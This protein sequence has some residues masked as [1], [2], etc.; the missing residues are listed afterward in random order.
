MAKKNNKKRLLTALTLLLLFFSGAAIGAKSALSQEQKDDKPDMTIPEA[1]L[2]NSGGSNADV[3]SAGSNVELS[4]SVKM[5]KGEAYVRFTVEIQD[6]DGISLSQKLSEKQEEIEQYKDMLDPQS[7]SYQAFLENYYALI[8]EYNQIYT[9]GQLAFSAIC[10]DTSNREGNLLE[11]DERISSGDISE[12]AQTGELA[13]LS[14]ADPNGLFIEDAEKS[15]GCTRTYIC[16]QAVSEGEEISLFTN[17]VIPS[18]WDITSTQTEQFTENDDGSFTQNLSEINNM[19][20]LGSGFKISVSAEIID[21]C[22]A[23]DAQTAFACAETAEKTQ[24]V[25]EFSSDSQ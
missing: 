15:D 18:D 7:A 3:L 10:R 24:A 2:V 1:V 9:K 16:T 12:L 21:A 20:L 11:T 19:Q 4:S 25:S 5:D 6:A 14:E 8:N 13:L 17:V 23:D 22:S